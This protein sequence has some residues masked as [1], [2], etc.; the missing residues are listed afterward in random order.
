MKVRIKGCDV[1][2]DEEDLHLIEK[3]SWR[4]QKRKHGPYVRSSIPVNGKHVDIYLH[5][6]IANAPEGLVVDHINGDGLD[7]RKCNLRVCTHAQNLANQKNQKRGRSKYKGV[8]WR[9]NANK[10]GAKIMVEGK[11][12]W[13]GYHSL[14]SAAAQAYNEA[15]TKYLG[16]FARL[17]EI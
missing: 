10:W 3:Y 13:L 4:I 15:A 2:L 9:A 8:V 7:N 6:I 14:E 1:L 16:M 11:Y 12:I 17:N 5:R